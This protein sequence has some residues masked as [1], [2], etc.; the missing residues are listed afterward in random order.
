MTGGALPP[1]EISELTVDKALDIAKK[2]REVRRFLNKNRVMD[3]QL[4]AVP[5]LQAELIIAAEKKAKLEEV[6]VSENR[7]KKENK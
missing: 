4:N 6:H 5:N 2:S 1:H 7:V 3:I